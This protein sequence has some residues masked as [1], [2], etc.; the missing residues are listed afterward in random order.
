MTM[1]NLRLFKY[2][3]LPISLSSLILSC[4][5]LLFLPDCAGNTN[6]SDEQVESIVKASVEFDK[7]DLSPISDFIASER[8]IILETNDSCLLFGIDRLRISNDTIYLQSSNEIFTFS[9][10]GEWLNY[11]MLQGDGSQEYSAID[12][13]RVNDGAIY[14]LDNA[15][16]KIISYTP[17]G[18][19]IKSISTSYD[20]LDFFVPDNDHIVLAS[21]NFN[22]SMHN[23]TWID[24]KTG[25][26]TDEFA[27]YSISRTIIF[28][29]YIPFSGTDGDDLIVNTPFCL[30]DFRMNQNSFA[31]A[32]K[33]DF[34]PADRMPQF[35]PESLDLEKM[36]DL[37]RQ[38]GYYGAKQLGYYTSSDSA[39]YLSFMMRFGI[40]G[41]TSAP[42]ATLI[43]KFNR[44]G[45]ETGLLFPGADS[46]E[47][48]PYFKSMRFMADG[49]LVSVINAEDLLEKDKSLNLDYWKSRGLTEDSNPVVFIYKL[50]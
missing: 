47:E 30:T 46:S 18:Q 14:I 6:N 34:Q 35:S 28:D 4:S 1:K 2:Q 3:I 40:K 10:E 23:F 49:N 29:D 36:S 17:D 22:R 9:P 26:I 25:E 12:G 38:S 39:R 27:P 50:K 43:L 24:P 31:P 7:R 42:E 44:E 19:F 13:F 32:M 21:G 45:E 33:F 15:G 20:Y 41:T 8:H 5:M 11:F 48:F 37:L 16:R